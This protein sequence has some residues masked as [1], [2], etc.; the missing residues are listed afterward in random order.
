MN[1]W[2]PII[3]MPEVNFF[4]NLKL[5]KWL[6]IVAIIFLLLIVTVFALSAGF[7]HFY[8]NKIYPGIYFNDAYL[9]G[10]TYEGAQ[11][12]IEQKTSSYSQNGLIFKL[13]GKESK[14]YPISS[15]AE[16]DF[17]VELM[18]IETDKTLE[19][20][21][22]LGRN[23]SFFANKLQQI[24]LLLFPK[25]INLDLSVNTEEIKKILIADLSIFDK[26]GKDAALSYDGKIFT[27]EKEIYGQTINYSKGID[28]LKKVLAAG[29]NKII[30][31][32]YTSSSPV[33]LSKDCLNI[34]AQG[35][36]ILNLAPIKLTYEKDS[37]E[38]KKA[39]LAEMLK[40]KKD[41]GDKVIIGLD[42]EVVAEYLT[43]VPGEKI[44]VEAKD[45]KFKMI[46]NR[47]DEFQNSQD[48]IEIDLASTTSSLEKAVWEGRKEIT[49]ITRI[50][51]SNL[52]SM[53]TGDLN[54]Q[55]IIG[56]GES[57]FSGSPANRRH[58]IRIGANSVNGILIKPDEEFSLN[59]TLGEI[60]GST[61]YKQE[62]VIKDNKT[63][64]EYGGGLCQ[65]GTTM[66]RGALASGLPITMRRN[67]S[68]RV[69]YYE[70][71]GTD[72]TIYDPFPDLRFI[73]DTGNYILIQSKI[74]GNKLYFEFWG[75]KDGRKITKTKPTIYDITPPP[76][77]KLVETTDLKPGE[78][79]CTE[80]AHSGAKAYFDY[81]VVYPDETVKSVRFSSNYVPWQEVCLIG[82]KSLSGNA[83]S[84]APAS[85][86]T[87][88]MISTSTKPIASSSSTP[89]TASST[90]N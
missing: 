9:S 34:Q 1:Y 21:L 45:A 41:D 89:T 85:S 79:K 78:K 40:L 55:E 52:T 59:K 23:G 62:L 4:K 68:Y 74:V 27:V 24:N 66:F 38:I 50:T 82:V 70:P 36:T 58:N 65:I 35:D 81:K 20:L 44:N 5:P 30:D 87:P 39:K 75:K 26:P 46:G 84:T 11:S 61:G 88:E 76:P 64:P 25:K 80:K 49:I 73:N 16:G 15:S 3:K 86:S 72:A 7:D 60:D 18:I 48:G 28:D 32:E 14:I 8:K 33:I 63:I 17:T 47:V 83:S 69:S 6:L 56:V 31:L 77:T 67:H 42:E 71:A 51:K 53:D 57:N 10:L 19:R 90:K 29:E 2:V 12:I 22:S 54:I 43:G 37:W 13:A